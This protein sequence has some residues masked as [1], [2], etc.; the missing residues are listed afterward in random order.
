M[1]DE[2]L[3]LYA[4]EPLFCCIVTVAVPDWIER[5]GGA[6]GDAGGGGAERAF[7]S[8]FLLAATVLAAVARLELRRSPP[9]AT[10]AER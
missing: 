10:D 6:G 1:E 7:A 4:L 9:V 2:R 3:G 5:I 8:V